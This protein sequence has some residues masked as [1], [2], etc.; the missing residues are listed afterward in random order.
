MRKQ[1]ITINYR[2]EVNSIGR[3]EAGHYIVARAL[4]FKVGSI[5][6]CITDL[7]SNGHAASSEIKLHCALYT[8][9]EIQEYLEKRVLVL[10]AGSLAQ[11]LVGDKV[12]NESAHKIIADGGKVDYAKA[13]EAIHLIRN[14]RFPGVHCEKE[15]QEGLD[16]IGIELWN[17]TIKLVEKDYEIINLLGSR[18]GSELKFVGQEFVLTEAELEMLPAIKKR[19]INVGNEV[20]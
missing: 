3:H 11:S 6:I 9:T 1:S 5:S 10:Y 14:I 13:R 20:E 4:G 18:L 8:V 7:I 17:K 2:K 16:N 15:V 12:D 19:F